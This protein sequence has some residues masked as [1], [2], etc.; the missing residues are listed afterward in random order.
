MGLP[1]SI[2]IYILC[3]SYNANPSD[4]SFFTKAKPLMILI[5]YILKQKQLNEVYTGGI[6]SYSLFLMIISFLQQTNIRLSKASLEELLIDF[7]ELYGCEFNYYSV[8][9]SVSNAAYFSKE[10]RGW[11][12]DNQGLLLAIEDPQDSDNVSSKFPKK[13]KNSA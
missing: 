1:C 2:Y 11:S 3:N 7:C 4:F 5:K 9:I 12:Y 13:K 10:D 6:G 8:G